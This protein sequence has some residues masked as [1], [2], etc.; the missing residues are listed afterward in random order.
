MNPT[1]NRIVIKWMTKNEGTI[2]SIRKKFRIPQYTT[3]NGWSPV[4]VDSDEELG[5]L[6]ECERRGFISILPHTWS[7]NGGNYAFKIRK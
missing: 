6:A 4:Q 7:K 5:L 2:G 1:E 3:L